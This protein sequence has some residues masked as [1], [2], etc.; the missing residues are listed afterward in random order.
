MHSTDGI[1]WTAAAA[2]E[3]N[4]WRSV[5]Y[6]NGKFVAVSSDGINRVMHSSDGIT[7]TAAAA[8]ESN[9]WRSVTYGNGK[10]VAVST[11]GTNRVMHSSDQSSD[12][13][14]ATLTLTGNADDHQ[15]ADDVADIT[16]TFNDTA[17]NNTP[18]A[19][20]TGQGS[21]G[22]G[23][24]FDDYLEIAWAG[25][26][27]ESTANDGS[28]T[29][30]RTATLS[31]D[32][33]T[34]AVTDGNPFTESTHYTVANVPAGMTAVLTKTSS[35]L[36]TLTLTGNATSHADAN[37]VANLTVT[38]LDG[39]FTTTPTASNVTNYTDATGQVDFADQPSIAYDASTFTEAVAND[40]SISTTVNITL[41]GD[42]FATVGALTGGGTD[43]TANNVPAGLTAAITT[44]S[45]TAGTLT[46]TG[47]ATSHDDVDDIAN[48]EIIWADAAFTNVAAA[49][50][51]NSTKSDFV[52][53]FADQPSI[54]YTGAGFSEVTASNDGSVTGSIIATLTGDTFQDTDADDVLD[55]TLELVLGNVPAGLTAVI[56]LSAG[57]TVATLTFTGNATNHTN[58]FDVADITFAFQDGAFTNTTTASDVTNATGPASSSLGVDFGPPFID[59]DAS[60]FTEVVANDGSI[61]TTVN[62]TLTGDTFT[63][64][65]A[66]TGGGTHFT[67]NNVPAGLTAAITTTSTTAGTLTLTGNATAHADANDI[68]N[69]EIIWADAAFTNVAAADITRSTKSDFVVDF[70]DNPL[71]ELSA[72][73]A[74]AEA[75]GGNLPVILVNGTV[76]NATTVDIA[77][78]GTGTATSG[79]DYAFTSPQT[80][81]IPAGTY[82][83]LA[84][85]AVSI[86]T[87]AI[88]D[89]SDVESDETINLTLSNATGDAIIGDADGDTSTD[90]AQTYTINN[91]DI[92][93]ATITI[94]DNLTG[95]DGD[96]GTFQI[97]L[98]S[99]PTADVTIALSSD[100]T[101]EGTVGAS[102]TIT[103]ANWNNPAAN[104]VTVTGVDDILADGLENYNIITGNVTSIDAFYDALD[105]TTIDDVAMQ[106]QNDDLASSILLNLTD[107]TSGEDGSTATVQ[108]SLAAQPDGGEDVTIPVS[109]DDSTEGTLNGVTEIVILNADWNTP[110]NNE[111]TITGVDDTDID[112]DILYTF[113]TGDPTSA[114]AGYNDLTAADIADPSLTNTDDDQLLVEFTDATASDVEADGGSISTLTVSGAVSTLSY[115]IDVADL[116]TGTATSGVDY[117]F[118]T[119]R[120]ITIPAGDYTTPQTIAT[121][122]LTI[123]NESTV[124]SDE[125]IIF[126]VQ[127]PNDEHL[128]VGDADGDATT[129]TAH[130]YTINDDDSVLGLSADSGSSGSSGS[131][132]G[133]GGGGGADETPPTVFVPGPETVFIDFEIAK[134]DVC[135]FL[136]IRC[137]IWYIIAAIVILLIIYRIFLRG[138][139]KA[140]FTGH[141]RR[142][143]EKIEK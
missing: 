11:S 96:T 106:N 127:N 14:V 22:L 66:L 87:L 80:V 108:F 115:M 4:S 7:W 56:T 99:E 34:A 81:T 67:A 42:T 16:F 100:D 57:D 58:A 132:A 79:T 94:I 83:G 118:S 98:T 84:G 1:T 123:Y 13:T 39:V 43:F 138:R 142:V 120:T 2:T 121:G 122:G 93:G 128:V 44:T 136:G 114:H 10:F 9:S 48:L 133:G 131:G 46:L 26:F 30:T 137:W 82:D 116:G 59:Y 55:E 95:E 40:G 69:L 103:P 5:A 23:V 25:D 63:T 85:T 113:I 51:T 126:Q 130:T 111:I 74:D 6:G 36:A 107:V 29:G 102:I 31:G 125:T 53:D 41:T 143:R 86:T 112:G 88:M 134:G 38:F 71:V 73:S 49:N 24:D 110:A 89:D 52:V 18:T 97:E 61:A 109:L 101:D 124:E 72:D 3:A 20:V 78:A 75:S 92:A 21:S 62:I 33:Y 129:N 27:T 70:E 68:S 77:D 19:N 64:V 141:R 37:D 28:V 15:D 12:E 139:I 32:T 140:I 54:A 8:A 76:I 45:T 50:I 104:V 91:D 90:T 47:N 35:T 117:G 135:Y 119:P 60:T 65:G 17:F 105:G